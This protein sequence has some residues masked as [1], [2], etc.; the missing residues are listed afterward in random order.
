LSVNYF[1]SI[2]ARYIY[3][4]AN[5]LHQGTLV[6]LKLLFAELIFVLCTAYSVQCSVTYHKCCCKCRAVQPR[7]CR[8]VNH[9]LGLTLLVTSMSV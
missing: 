6:P 5:S 7:I 8:S 1:S 4:Q 9:S 2:T 3:Y